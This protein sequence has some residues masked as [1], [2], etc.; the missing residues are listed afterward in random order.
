MK[1]LIAV[2]LALLLAAGAA[3]AQGGAMQ[4]DSPAFDHGQPIPEKYSCDGQDVSPPL[5]ISGVPDNARSL[6][7]LSDDP[8]APPGDWVHW[9]I[10]NLPPDTASLPENV[11]PEPKLDNGAAQGVNSFRKMGY[12]G[13]CPPSGTHRYFFKLYALD[14]E[15]DLK[16]GATKQE[17]LDAMQAHTIEQTE[18]M[19]TYAR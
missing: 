1:T 12:G 19:G 9:I 8:D 6:A 11:P 18:L 2:A 10:F 5:Q 15:L 17:L 13:P 4:L 16:P 7:L 3:G 14:T